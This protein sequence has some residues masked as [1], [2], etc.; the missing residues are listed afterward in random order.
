MYILNDYG[1]TLKVYNTDNG[2]PYDVYFV[3]MTLCEN[4]IIIGTYSLGNP[5]GIFLSKDQGL[6]WI[7]VSDSSTLINIRD[8]NC[9]ENYIFAGTD[10]GIIISSNCGE[11]WFIPENGLS[12]LHI[13]KSLIL[14]SNIYA[15]TP[16]GVFKAP[17][18]D[19][20]IVNVKESINEK[21]NY[22]Y[23]YPP[24]PNPST[25]FVH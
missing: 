24:Y 5:T 19:F 8:L 16:E 14:D 2:L 23:C 11:N 15:A 6:S 9:Y 3:A 10:S 21:Q 25:N 1:K 20:G 18:S 7:C 13:S 22:L 4:N 17:L 12:K